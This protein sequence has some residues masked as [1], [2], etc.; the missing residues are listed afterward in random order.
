MCR[1]MN[2]IRHPKLSFASML[3]GAP[4]ELHTA[5]QSWSAASNKAE[6]GRHCKGLNNRLC[7]QISGGVGQGVSGQLSAWHSRQPAACA[8]GTPSMLMLDKKH[9]P[10]CRRAAQLARRV[11]ASQLPGTLSQSKPPTSWAAAARSRLP[12]L[13]RSMLRCSQQFLRYVGPASTHCQPS[14]MLQ[15]SHHLQQPP[16]ICAT[17]HA[18]M[19]LENLVL[20]VA[21]LHDRC[22]LLHSKTLQAAFS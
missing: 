15:F 14:A 13:A 11:T 7:V 19:L 16:P 18:A 12:L 9:A 4:C 6:P 2:C 21:T 1:E 5:R 17:P 20:P 8:A 3:P 10:C 22:A